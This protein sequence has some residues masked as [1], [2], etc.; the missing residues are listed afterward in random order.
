MEHVSG[1]SLWVRPMA[2]NTNITPVRKDLLG[3]NTLAYSAHSK[4]TRKKFANMAP[5][6]CSVKIY[7]LKIFHYI[8]LGFKGLPGAKTLA[9]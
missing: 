5:W 2:L 8:I 1:A 7:D 6:E 4:V 3:T 9:S